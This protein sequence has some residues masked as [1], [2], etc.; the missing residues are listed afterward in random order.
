MSESA[1]DLARRLLAS[2]SPTPSTKTSTVTPSKPTR[3]TTGTRTRRGP[4][5]QFADHPDVVASMDRR[6]LTAAMYAQSSMVVPT[7]LART[8]SNDTV[9]RVTEPT[10]ADT[11]LTNFN[12]YDY[13]GLSKHPQVIES[14]KQ[15]LDQYGCSAAAAR[16]VGG[17]IPL[18]R[19]LEQRLADIYDVD[20]ALVSAS[21]F[22]T[23]AGVIGFL[24]KPGDVAICDTLIHGSVI[25]GIQWSG[26][27][28]LTFRHNDPESLRAVLRT[29]RDSFDRALVVV[30]GLYSMEG[31]VGRVREI[32][33]VAREFDCAVMVDEAHSFGV[34]G[35]HGYGIRE[36]YR[37]AGDS[38]DIWMGTLSKALGSSGGFVAANRDLIGAMKWNSPAATLTVGPTPPAIA[39]TLKALDIMEA[40]P[41][42]LKRLWSNA[43]EFQALLIERGLDLGSAEGTPICPV[44]MP[45]EIRSGYA[46]SMLLQRGVYAGCI[47]SPTVPMGQ[48]RLRLFVTSEHKE[49]QLV[50]AAD[51]IAE[52]VE[53]AK[54]LPDIKV[55]I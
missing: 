42:R 26:A 36:H 39:A 25:S 54:Q 8:G 52:V 16:G 2:S 7:F 35:D 53:L 50:S 49:S 45:G 6:E 1:Q 33:D 20:D 23:N 55:S 12:A 19:E 31:T 18:Y 4:G 47:V 43:T 32:A 3:A 24:L 11:D 13:L 21:G 37:M 30:E 5:K 46:S 48:E 9:V 28:R 51:V 29:S 27:R 17:E 34:F 38:V 14:A 15:A 44:M 40:E 41:E 22:L 10:L